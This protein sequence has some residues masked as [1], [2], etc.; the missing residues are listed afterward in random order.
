MLPPGTV[1]AHYEIEAYAGSGETGV[2]YRA[3]DVRLDRRVALRVIAPQYAADAVVRARLNREATVAASVSHPNTVPVYDAGEIDDTAYIVTQWVDGITLRDLVARDGPL[4]PERA[5]GLLNQIAGALEAAHEAGLVHRGV[6][7]TNVL[8]DE[9][10]VGYLTDFGLTRRTT[11]ASGLTATHQLLSTMD[12]VAPEQVE[13][14]PVDRRADVYSLGCL[15]YFLLAGEPPFPRR[16][17]AAILYAHLAGDYVPLSERRDDVP[18][19]LERAVR[20]AMSRDPD[21]RPPTAGAFARMLEHCSPDGAPSPPPLATPA[22]VPP[23]RRAGWRRRSET[24]AG[25]GAALLLAAAGT[26]VYLA[27][28][29]RSAGTQTLKVGRAA[30]S[31]SPSSSG[32]LVAG[33]PSG[34]VTSLT[35]TGDRRRAIDVGG[36]ANRVEQ[37]A[38]RIYV[39]GGNR[40]AVLDRRAGRANRR[41]VLPGAAAALSARSGVAWV[42]LRDRP[43]LVRVGA[44]TAPI[45][46]ANPAVA[47][48]AAGPAVWV[49]DRVGQALLRFDAATGVLVSRVSVRGR[50]AALAVAG[51]RLWVVN[52]SRHAVLKLDARTGA[53]AG[54]PIP[55][56]GTPTAVAADRREVWVVSGKRNVATRIDARSGRPEDEV[57]VAVA[58]RSVALTRSAAWVVSARGAVTRIPR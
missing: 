3:R 32:V 1:F 23:P 31:V 45:A 42:A 6:T 7:P 2:V 39:A 56:A 9:Y 11:D 13:G 5:I 8:V 55:V 30:A 44:A 10:G 54:P 28:N 33:G 36:E 48:Q 19:E 25:V 16:A 21:Q 27:L 57:G 22:P 41:V 29:D 38:G 40:L 20:A 26:G 14:G 24:V 53:V 37:A 43:R 46:L 12:Y 50:P 47:V 58:P 18:P 51:N 34:T 49:A 35:G 4:G 17:P 15:A 52:P